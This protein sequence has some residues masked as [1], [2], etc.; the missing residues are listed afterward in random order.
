[1]NKTDSFNRQSLQLKQL[2]L[3]CCKPIS[4]SFLCVT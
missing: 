4:W 3:A 1:M 2:V